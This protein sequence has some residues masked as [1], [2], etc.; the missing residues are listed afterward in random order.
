MLLLPEQKRLFL[1]SE[2]GHQTK[3]GNPYTI[4]DEVNHIKYKY[5]NT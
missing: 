5:D 2:Q 4:T 1:I 3:S